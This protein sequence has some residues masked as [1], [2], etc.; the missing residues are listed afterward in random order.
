MGPRSESGETNGVGVV[1]APIPGPTVGTGSGSG[2]TMGGVGETREGVG[3]HK[4]RPYE[5]LFQ[6]VAV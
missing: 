6:G 3:A 5:G 1:A 4:R 2:K